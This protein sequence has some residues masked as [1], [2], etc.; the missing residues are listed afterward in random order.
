MAVIKK[1]SGLRFFSFA[2]DGILKVAKAERNFKI[3]TFIAL[4]V[5]LLGLMVGLTIG[6]WLVIILVIFSILAA[7]TFNSAI[8]EICNL[9]KKKHNLAYEETKN[10]R[11]IAAGAVLFL[12]IASVVLGLIIFLPYFFNLVI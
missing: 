3:H 6:E 10:I 11:N 4:L 9:M 2:F 7:E 8:E 12:V 1:L 5:F